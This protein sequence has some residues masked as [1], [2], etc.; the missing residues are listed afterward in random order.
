MKE[1]YRY[2]NPWLLV[3]TAAVR[4]RWLAVSNLTYQVQWSPDF[5]NWS[6]LLSVL[7]KG[8][9]TNVIDWTENGTRRF[10]RLNV[11]R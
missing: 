7:G 8:A 1:L 2:D 10:Y 5:Q 4:L 6:N 11:V 3:E 9:E